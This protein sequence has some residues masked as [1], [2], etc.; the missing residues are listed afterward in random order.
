MIVRLGQESNIHPGRFQP[1][2]KQQLPLATWQS[3]ARVGA[4]QLLPGATQAKATRM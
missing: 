2:Q 4:I 3:A 1:I